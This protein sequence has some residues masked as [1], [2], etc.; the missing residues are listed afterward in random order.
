MTIETEIKA[1]SGLLTKLAPTENDAGLMTFE[2]YGAVFNNVDS[3]GDVIAP[4]AFAQTLAK[5]LADETRPLMFL[6]HAAA[7]IPVG[8]WTE[9][10][11]DG[12]GLKVKGQLIDTADGRDVYTALKA[13]AL[14]GLSIGFRPVEFQ[15]RA[16]PEDPRRT[17][18]SVELVE[19]SVVTLPANAKAR[20]Q[21]VKSMDEEPMTT[22]DLEHLL[23]DLGCSK[24]EAKTIASRFEP[25]A[26]EAKAREFEALESLLATLRK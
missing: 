26:D 23:R 24:T 14:N 8:V 15:M 20:I 22:R 18:K 7:S 6:N 2:G 13:G 12:Y 16:K 17:L 10:S 11:E 25:K 9:L 19:V 5:H 1:L 21:A 3:Y 4:G